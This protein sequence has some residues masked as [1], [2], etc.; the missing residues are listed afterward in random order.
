MG[1][2]SELLGS[3]SCCWQASALLF[4]GLV[5][6]HTRVWVCGSILC[7]HVDLQPE[8]S[9]LIHPR[10]LCY[11]QSSL[12]WFVVPCE[13]GSMCT[14]LPFPCRISCRLVF[15]ATVVCTVARSYSEVN[16]PLSSVLPR[17]DQL[18]TDTTGNCCWFFPFK[19]ANHLCVTE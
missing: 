9:A 11:P 14:L 10:F 13:W 3:H 1:M 18:E 8:Q 7:I 17:P 6:C 19:L 15:N 4:Q 12:G 16:F 5:K 2:P